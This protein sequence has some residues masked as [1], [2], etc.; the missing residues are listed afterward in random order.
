[1][2]R[3]I[4]TRLLW[5]AMLC[6]GGAT[7]AQPIVAPDPFPVASLSWAQTKLDSMTLEQKIGQLFMI[8]AYSNKSEQENAYIESLIREHHIGGL[9]FMQGGPRRQVHLIN[10][11]QAASG[12]PLLISQDAEW[13]NAMRLDSLLRFPRHMT[14][15]AIT[16]DS[17]L[18]LLGYQ[19][20][21]QCRALGVTVSFSPVVDINTNPQNPVIGDR[22]FGENKFN[23]A[24]KGGM[25]MKGLQAAGVLACAKHFPGHGDT[26]TD[27]HLDLPVVKHS[28]ARLDTMELYPFISLANAG[29]GSMMVAHLYIPALDNTPNLAST[30]SPVVVQKLLK[31]KIG[32]KGLVFTDA[33]NMKGVAKFWKPGEADIKALLAGNDV[34][35]FSGDVAKAAAKIKEA[36]SNGTLTMVQLNERVIKI[37]RAK[38]MLGLRTW[39]PLPV[40]TVNTINTTAVRQLRQTLFEASMTLLNNKDHLIPFKNL[41]KRSIAYVQ[42]GKGDVSFGST[43]RKYTSVKKIK[44][45]AAFSQKNVIDSLSAYN[46]VIVGVYEMNRMSSGTWG[47]TAGTV[48]AVKKLREQGKHVVVVLFGSPYAAYL[49]SGT[50]AILIA[51]EQDTDAEV[52]AAEALFGANPISGKLP[53]SSGAVFPSGSGVQVSG[54]GRFGFSEPIEAGMD[55]EWLAM[56]DSVATEIISTGAAPGLVVLALRGNR[57]IYDKG[58]GKTEYFGGVKVDPYTTTYDLASVTK[59][60]ATTVAV[61]RLVQEKKIALNESLGKYLPEV[62]GTDK[63]GIRIRELMLHISGLKP[64]IPLYTETIT[65]EKTWKDDFFADH[66]QKG[67]SVPICDGM[68]LKSAYQDTLWNRLVSST[69]RKDKSMVYSDLS[70][71][72]MQKVVERVSGVSM[73]HYLDSVFYQPLGM[74]RSTFNP[75]LNRPDLV[76]APTEMD[77]YWRMKK[78]QGYVHDQSAA[79]LG[80]VSGNA[81]LFSNAYDLAKL[82]LMLKN[83]GTYG[84]ER[85]LHPEIIELFTRFH[86]KNSRRGLGWDKPDPTPG[87][88]SPVPDDAGLKTYGH[89]GFTG[90]CVWVDPERDLIYIFLSNRTFPDASNSLLVKKGYR[91]IIHQYIYNSFLRPGTLGGVMN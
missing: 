8:A 1:M 34:L 57:I 43:L 80:G 15:G 18:Y 26:N 16:N 68:Y 41:D 24:R 71:I 82:L 44:V 83:G 81:G 89:L 76:C 31:E 42:V 72:F 85:F 28:S 78:I 87:K 86:Q 35:L 30:L 65:K 84:N 17:L 14:L 38:Y 69:L 52:A 70:M 23:V 56:I 66:P 33:L 3:E 60:C 6:L 22:S 58:Y 25:L 27:S 46:T 75:G 47:I 13:G 88:I 36:L 4:Y 19:L 50:D 39:K 49:F 91:S 67:Y 63:A 90:I 77:Q 73:D 48:D 79:M 37:L 45:D 21:L 32:F 12:I 61:M 7:L 64:F 59:V 20:G 74:D 29:V 40:P 54:N 53:V 51:Y 2:L 55:A 10:R 5:V 11:F 62:R 9:I